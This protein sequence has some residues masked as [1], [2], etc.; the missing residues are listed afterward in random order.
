MDAGAEIIW[1]LQEDNR[2]V[3]GTAE[4]CMEI[5]DDL[6]NPDVGWCVGDDQTRPEPRVFDSSPF[7]I[8]RGFDLIVPTS[9]ME[10]VYTTSHG[11]PGGNENLTG[12]E[13]LAEVERVI[14]QLP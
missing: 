12:E 5:M 3:P 14:S 11:T 7:A 8:G 9:T 1:V 2:Q 6:G 4:R 13:V 10:I